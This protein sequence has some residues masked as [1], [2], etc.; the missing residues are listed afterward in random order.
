MATQT[1]IPPNLTDEDKASIFQ[2]LDAELNSLILTTLLHGIYTGI[3]AVTLWNIF[4]NKCSPTRRAL[5]VII[6]LLHALTTISFAAQWSFI[7]STFI[8]NRQSFWTVYL[9]FDAMNHAIYLAA[10]I[11][12]CMSTILAD[13]YIIWCCWMVWGQRWLIVLLP[14]LSLISATVSKII[15]VYRQYFNATNSVFLMPFSS[16]VLATTLWCT[17]LIIFRILTV[18]SV[19]HGGGSQLR[20]YHQFIEVLVESSALYSISLILYLAF[21]SRNYFTGLPYF[22][23]IAAIARGVAPTFLVGRAAAGHTHPTEEQDESATVST[24]LFQMSSQSSQPSQPSTSSFLESTRQSA[25]LEMDIEAQTEQ[26]DEFVV[27]VERTQ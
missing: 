23:A 1:D 19:R 11:P 7:C 15:S 13:S 17:L 10:G 20:V 21:V 8:Q 2:V 22:D 14:I 3:L 5:A 4:I 24:L 16:L 9:K 18:T 25:V 12:S 26:L 27:V 6:I